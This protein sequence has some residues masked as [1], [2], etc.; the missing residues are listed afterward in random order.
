MTDRIRWASYAP[1]LALVP[2]GTAQSGWRPIG[3]LRL[4]EGAEV[5]DRAVGPQVGGLVRSAEAVHQHRAQAVGLGAGDVPAVGGLERD[6]G[7]LGA[8]L[9]E[10]D[11]VH[12]RRR[13]E[14]ARVHHRDHG[15]QDLVE[16]G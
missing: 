9:G 11:L 10:A 16:L 1:V 14:D 7:W 8:E 3:S 4:E 6:V 13:L 2:G 15:V 5:T 12:L